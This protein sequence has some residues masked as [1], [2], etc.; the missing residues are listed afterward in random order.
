LEKTL[1]GEPAL[2]PRL[3]KEDQESLK[4]WRAFQGEQMALSAEKEFKELYNRIYKASTKERIAE[5][6]RCLESVKQLKLTVESLHAPEIQQRIQRD[7][8]YTDLVVDK[9]WL[10]KNRRPLIIKVII[11]VAVL[12]VGG[13]VFW[14]K[15]AS[16]ES[17]GPQDDDHDGIENANDLEPNT[18]WPLDTAVFKLKDYVDAVGKL[19]PKK[20]QELCDCWKVPDIAV[21][22]QLSCKDNANWWMFGDSL[23]EMRVENGNVRFYSGEGVLMRTQD[24]NDLEKAHRLAFPEFYASGTPEP[25]LPPSPEPNQKITI[26]YNGERYKIKQG[27]TSEKGMEYSHA[28]WRYRNNTWQKAPEPKHPKWEEATPKDVDHLLSRPELATK[29]EQ[30]PPSPP[31]TDPPQPPPLQNSNLS[32]DAYWVE[33]SKLLATDDGKKNLEADVC[34][35]KKE[36]NKGVK[37]LLETTKTKRMNVLNFLSTQLKN[38]P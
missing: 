4:K 21:R 9:T 34:N 20:I 27:F 16:S 26:T 11:S 24:D 31:V 10:P 29:L 23:Y 5:K 28:L 38:C 19:A 8:R 36:K 15:P 37:G 22:K 35:I 14:L 13:L 1:A 32:T 6:E 7:Q 2:E 25:P 17:I 33:K 12:V 18:A 30:G 3:K